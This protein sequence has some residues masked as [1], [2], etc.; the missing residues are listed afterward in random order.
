MD[1]EGESSNDIRGL[2]QGFKG[3]L[4]VAPWP[5]GLMPLG[6]GNVHGGSSL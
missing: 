6:A 4:D 3:V 2:G 1:G 5:A